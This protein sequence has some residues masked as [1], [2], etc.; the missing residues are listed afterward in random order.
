[1][2]LFFLSRTV[3]E[4]RFVNEMSE[5]GVILAEKKLNIRFVDHSTDRLVT[6]LQSSVV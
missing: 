1:M 6:L 4:W 3:S 2:Q 5:N